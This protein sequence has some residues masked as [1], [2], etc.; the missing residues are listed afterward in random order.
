MKMAHSKHCEA[1]AG[2]WM[3]SKAL[4]FSRPV[5]RFEVLSKIL[6]PQSL[7]VYPLILAI[8]YFGGNL[9]YHITRDLISPFPCIELGLSFSLGL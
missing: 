1:T 7:Q 5:K 9:V 6:S 3:L 8:I 4:D 2:E